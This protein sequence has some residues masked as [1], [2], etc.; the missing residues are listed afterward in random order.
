[1]SL[2]KTPLDL[3]L[4]PPLI[5]SYFYKSAMNIAVIVHPEARNTWL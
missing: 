2:K 1:M 3:P 5:R 4:H